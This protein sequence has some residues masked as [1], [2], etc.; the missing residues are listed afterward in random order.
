MTLNRH[1]SHGCSHLVLISQPSRLRQCVLSVLLKDATY[2]CS[3]DLNHRSLYPQTDILPMGPICHYMYTQVSVSSRWS[4]VNLDT[5]YVLIVQSTCL[6]DCCFQIM[7]HKVEQLPVI[8]SMQASLNVRARV[9]S[10]LCGLLGVL[11]T[12]LLLLT[13]LINLS[14]SLLSSLLG[15]D[16]VAS[17]DTYIVR[18]RVMGNCEVMLVC[19]PI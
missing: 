7:V 14:H 6:T 9:R 17:F 3:L 19:E 11:L 13:L 18:N 5:M 1:H 16:L 4:S 12:L 2:C 10:A 15:E 8:F